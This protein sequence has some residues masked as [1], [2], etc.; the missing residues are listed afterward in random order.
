MLY[1]KKFFLLFIFFSQIIIYNCAG[2]RS[3]ET[4]TLSFITIEEELRLGE[5]LQSFTI[6]YLEIIRNSQVNQFFTDMANVIGGVSHW[7]G[8]DYSV[9]VINEQHSALPVDVCFEDAAGQLVG[10]YHDLPDLSRTWTLL[11]PD[12]NGCVSLP[13][14]GGVALLS[15]GNAVG[16]MVESSETQPQV[17]TNPVNCAVT[18]THAL[19]FRDAP[20]GSDIEH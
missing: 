2:T 15:G 3:T 14:L 20:A 8:L 5:E 18:T 13:A 12:A 4:D 11:Q 19:I 6:R 10:L 1:W 7:R 16:A 17:T 9:F